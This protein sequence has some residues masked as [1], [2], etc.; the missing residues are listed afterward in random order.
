MDHGQ[1]RLTVRRR[2]YCFG[3][4]TRQRYYCRIDFVH[5][6]V[7]YDLRDIAENLNEIFGLQ[8]L[9]SAAIAF[10]MVTVLIFDL[11]NL[12]FVST[13]HAGHIAYLLMIYFIPMISCY[14]LRV[15]GIISICST[16]STE[17]CQARPWHSKI[18]IVSVQKNLFQAQL[19]GEL[20]YEVITPITCHEIRE[21][22]QNQKLYQPLHIES[23]LSHI[24]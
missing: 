14:T 12:L 20:I 5:R 24:C 11:Y 8:I 6:R 22:V 17:V 16:T 2:H 15:F 9:L 21:E 23:L 3:N 10:C 19:T 7:H 13:K 18:G 4:C 1:V